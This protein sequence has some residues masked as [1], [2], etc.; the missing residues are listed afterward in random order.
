M[1]ALLVEDDELWN[2]LQEQGYGDFAPD[3]FDADDVDD[4]EDSI[5]VDYS[6][7]DKEKVPVRR[8]R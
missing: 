8:R 3:Q 2:Q 6:G 7:Q 5:D 4:D 1:E